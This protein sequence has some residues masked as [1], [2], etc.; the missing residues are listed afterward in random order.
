VLDNENKRCA[1]KPNTKHP[2]PN[3]VAKIKPKEENK[4]PE[5]EIFSQEGELVADVFETDS[6]FVVLATIAGVQMKDLDISVEKNMMVIKGQRPDP[7]ENPNK[8]YFCQ[9]CWW[10]PF[11]RKIVLPENIETEEASAQIDKGLLTI[12]IPKAGDQKKNVEVS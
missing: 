1:P 5:N 3:S 10:G 12:K 7:H 4:T 11:S 8:K 9:E 6:H 2:T